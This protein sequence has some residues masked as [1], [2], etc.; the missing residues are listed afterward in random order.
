MKN[1]KNVK[2]TSVKILEDLYNNFKKETVVSNFNLQKLV[3]RSVYK[4]VADNGYRDALHT[5]DAL[6]NSGSC[7]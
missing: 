2:L 7:F 6:L 3:N 4:Y 5:E 1:N